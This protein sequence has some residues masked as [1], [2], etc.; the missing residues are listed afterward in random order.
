[1]FTRKEVKNAEQPLVPLNL[2]VSMVASLSNNADSTGGHVVSRQVK[3]DFSIRTDKP[4][5]EKKDM[6]SV[7]EELDACVT[8]FGAKLLEAIRFEQGSLMTDQGRK[9]DQSVERSY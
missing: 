4:G 5:G 8:A 3:A 6:G 2:T 1:M 9:P 7:A